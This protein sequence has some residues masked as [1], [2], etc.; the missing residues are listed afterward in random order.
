MYIN[1]LLKR[2][3]IFAGHFETEKCKTCFEKALAIDANCTD[4][5]IHRA[6]VSIVDQT[7]HLLQRVKVYPYPINHLPFPF[8]P[9]FLLTPFLF[10]PS[11]ST[12]F[13]FTLSSSSFLPFYFPPLFLPSSFSSPSSPPY[14]LSSPFLL[15]PPSPLLPVFYLTVSSPPSLLSSPLPLSSFLPL[16]LSFYLTFLLLFFPLSLPF[17]LS[18]LLPLPLSLPLPLFL[19]LIPSHPGWLRIRRPSGAQ[20]CFRR[21]REGRQNGPQLPLRQLQPCVY[22]SPH[23]WSTTVCTD[24]GIGSRQI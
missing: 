8:L 21:L 6:R 5:F 10:L 3:G 22:L 24:T 2:G 1:A 16:S 9:L 11:L 20:C 12:S 17:F 4:V 15:S 13:S 14:F 23:C 18:L 19:F 7:N